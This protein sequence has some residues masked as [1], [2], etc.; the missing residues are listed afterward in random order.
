MPR[1]QIPMCRIW[2]DFFTCI[3]YGLQAYGK[4]ALDLNRI[5]RENISP[6]AISSDD[7]C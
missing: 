1:R 4:E 5:A 2:T 3:Q 7:H 6:R